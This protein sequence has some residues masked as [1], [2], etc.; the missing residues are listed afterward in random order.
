MI[1]DIKRHSLK[2]MRIHGIW[3]C[4]KSRCKSPTDKSYKNYG[5][6]GIKVC[7]LWDNS[8][9][10]FYDWA[11]SHGYSNKLMLDRIDN[12]GHYCPSNCEWVT[13]QERKWNKKDREETL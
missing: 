12:D 9:E 10:K 4:M 1:Y 3:G 6:R 13:I 2:G 5:A 11:V 8:Y 7:P